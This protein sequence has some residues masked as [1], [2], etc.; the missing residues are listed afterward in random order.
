M[1]GVPDRGDVVWIL[2][3]PQAGREQAGR[4]PALVLSPAAYNRKVGLALL[5]PITNQVKGYPFE[6][7]LPQG[8]P[9]TGVILADQVKSL[10]WRARKAEV[11]CKV[12]DEVVQ[13]ALLKLGTL[14]S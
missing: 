14:L 7:R 3:S 6:V 13:E 11:A 12:P 8:L 1:S 2:L 9:V 5:C 4:R 10:D